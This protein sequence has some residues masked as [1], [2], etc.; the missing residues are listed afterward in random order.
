MLPAGPTYYYAENTQDDSTANREKNQ[1]EHYS[2]DSSVFS[3]TVTA[4][5]YSTVGTNTATE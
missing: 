1:P 3:L 4:C 5:L 2:A